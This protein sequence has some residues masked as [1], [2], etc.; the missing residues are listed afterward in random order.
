[1]EYAASVKVIL[2]TQPGDVVEGSGALALAYPGSCAFSLSISTSVNLCFFNYK[3]D[4]INYWL[5]LSLSQDK[6]D[7][8]MKEDDKMWQGKRRKTARDLRNEVLEAQHTEAAFMSPRRTPM[9]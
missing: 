5:C 1:M 9:L 2:K 4:V 8:N 7:S 3:I 6:R